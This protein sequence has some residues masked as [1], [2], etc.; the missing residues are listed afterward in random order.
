MS[1]FVQRL[2]SRD[3]TLTV[4][5]FVR[6]ERPLADVTVLVSQAGGQVRTA[7]QW[8]HAVSANLPTGALRSLRRRPEL[9]RIQLV[10]RFVRRPEP[11]VQAVAP[12]APSPAPG[13]DDFGPS[14]M[15]YNRLNLMPLVNRGFRGQGV[16]I[17]ILD[18][19]F[20]TGL[21]VFASTTVLAQRDFINHDG[22]VREQPGECSN[23]HGTSTWS[24][25]GGNQ[26]GFILGIA[27]DA[28]YIL[29]RTE[30]ACREVRT[31]EDNYV[32]ALEW[33]DSLGAKVVSSSLGYFDFDSGFTYTKAQLNGD[34]AV[35]TIAVDIAAQKGITVVTAAGNEGPGT[36]TLGTPADADSAIVVGAVDSL[37]TL[38]L[39]SSRGPTG[40]V[41]IKPD[42]TA[43]GFR[44]WVA[45]PTGFNRAD[46]TS[47]STPITAGSAALLKQ[48]H[49]TF[50]PIDI[51]DALRAA[52]SN[53]RT[54]DSNRGW[55]TPDVAAAATF[56]RGIIVQNPRDSILTSVTPD[57]SWA[58]PDVPVFGLPAR[59]RLTVTTDAAF[60]TAP[61]LDTTLTGT[62]VV[63]PRALRPL[64][65]MFFRIIATG[66]DS[67][68]LTLASAQFVSPPWTKLETLGGPGNANIRATQPTFT[69][70]SPAVTA[71][72]GPFTYDV[73]VVRA[74]N[75]AVELDVR[76][77][78]TTTLVPPRPLAYNVAYRWLVTA[79]LGTDTATT[80]SPGT[81]T[82]IE[83]VFPTLTLLFQ[84]F[85]NPF[86]D[87]NTGRRSTCIWFDLATSGR[88]R[89]D[90]MDMR[91]HVVRSLVPG[92]AFDPE[93]TAGHYGRSGA[94]CDPALEWDGTTVNGTMVPQGIYIA[95]LVTPDGTSFKRIVFLGPGLF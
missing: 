86:P 11:A 54:P 83:D 61:V 2:L 12:F 38:V 3:T 76:D 41:R 91:G 57:F 75:G 40:D 14:I 24:L 63:M 7:S 23:F 18:T 36:Q 66:A 56:P 29:A 19:G 1:P 48:I 33:A 20:E 21:P 62:T 9:E 74:G 39:F 4:W 85:P 8:L 15:P 50:G 37:G 16:K 17:A 44:V 94:D 77:L 28:Q 52:G 46:G 92:S 81:F 89:L 53:A 6:P 78:T 59:Y 47:F 82:V 88:V 68:S 13:A 71:P 55:G 72:A 73:R 49:P 30:D 60:A 64:A 43:P 65:T 87:R 26:Q 5:L 95:K 22:V 84:N 35:T 32:A 67:A 58:T 69:W 34:F 51:R 93:L 27:R 70:S 42:V 31:E 10:A 25:L 45:T 80:A 79:R 90:I